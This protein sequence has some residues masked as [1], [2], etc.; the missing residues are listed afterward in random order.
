MSRA[1]TRRSPAHPRVGGE[2]DSS[3]ALFPKKCGSSPRGRGKRRYYLPLRL[4]GRLIP[5]WAGKT[6][7]RGGGGRHRR[8]HP[9]VGGENIAAYRACVGRAGSSPR[10]RGKHGGGRGLSRPVGL[11][12]AWAGKTRPRACIRSGTTAHP[13]VGGENIRPIGFASIAAGSS[14]R[15]RGKHYLAIAVVVK[16]GLIPAWAGKTDSARGQ[17]SARR[18][19]PRVGGENDNAAAPAPPRRGSS[20][21]GRGKLVHVKQR[22]LR[23]RL[24]PAWAG[25]TLPDAACPSGQWAHPRVG[26]ENPSSAR[27]AG[28]GAGSSPRGRG[29]RPH[30]G[31]RR[32]AGRLIPAWAGKTPT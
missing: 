24:I 29:K 22:V 30:P 10:G 16:A 26:G 27:S 21:R 15:G 6:H 4:T 2:N 8:A 1:L 13:R 28:R 14:P 19:H 20:P 31:P 23:L 5:A 7:R 18:A 9:R 11:I 32:G 17:G 12:P 3:F 25:K